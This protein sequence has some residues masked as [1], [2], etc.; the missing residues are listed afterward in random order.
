MPLDAYEQCMK[1]TTFLGFSSYL[2]FRGILAFY[3]EI[4]F[5]VILADSH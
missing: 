3:A 1:V 2:V 5:L 4:P